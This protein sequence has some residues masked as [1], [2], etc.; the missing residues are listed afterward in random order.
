M[1]MGD[2]MA[3]SEK[4]GRFHNA[5]CARL[6]IAHPILQSGMRGIAGPELVTQVCEH[7]GLGI[8]AGLQLPADV[9]RAQIAQVR[10]ATQRPFGVNLWLHPSLQPP[11]RAAAIP[12]PQLAGAQAELNRMRAQLQ[13]P[14]K[15]EPPGEVADTI[16]AAFEL[17]LQ[18][19]VP[20]FSVG[21]GDPGKERVARCHAAGITV[22]AMATTLAE[23]RALEAAG[24]DAIVAQGA[25]AGGHRSSWLEPDGKHDGVG[26]MT[27]VPQIV[28]AVRV[29]VI[30][31]GGIA[32]GR[33]LVAALALGAQAI[34]LG[35]RFVACR[36]SLAPPFFKQAVLERSSDATR[37]TRVYTGLPARGLRTQFAE[38]YEASGAPV[39]PALLQTNAAADIY[40]AALAKA[41]PEHYPMLA[42]QAIGLIHDLPSAA[43]IVDAIMRE[44]DAVRV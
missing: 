44:A 37:I 41:D 33:G 18:E 30:A 9:L 39:L 5:L 15:H 2:A 13:L 40:A 42:G 19:R 24:V 31:A 17:I 23:A 14:A 34:M 16:D 4:G 29:P 35:T 36:E 32:D 6:G 10:A 43:E 11:T 28:D 8:L 21:L 25:E 22:I 1:T 27:L 3:S 20:V 12:G 7:G 26:T 38:Q